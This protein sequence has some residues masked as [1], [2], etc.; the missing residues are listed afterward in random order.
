MGRVEVPPTWDITL[1]FGTNKGRRIHARVESFGVDF[2]DAM[3]NLTDED[4]SAAGL[5]RDAH[6]DLADDEVL[7]DVNLSAR[8]R[9]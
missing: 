7:V 3:D 9:G 1:G 5:N 6:P 4:L 8:R 2:V